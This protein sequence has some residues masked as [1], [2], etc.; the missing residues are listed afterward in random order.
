MTNHNPNDPYN[1]HGRRHGNDENESGSGKK[2]AGF[3]LGA[4]LIAGIAAAGLYLVDVDQTQEARLPDVNVSVEKG[5]M[6]AFDVDV[7]DVSVTQE[8]VEVEV[9]TMGVETETRTIEVEVP[10][11]VETGSTTETITVPTLNIER[12]TVDSP[13]NDEDVD[14]DI[15]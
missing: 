15:D 8:E 3:A 11:D 2:I 10:V 1:R 9:P 13:D 4:V 6:P 7:A 12:P 5:Q 14:T